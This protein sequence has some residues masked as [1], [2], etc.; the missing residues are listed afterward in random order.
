MNKPKGTRGKNSQKKP[1]PNTRSSGVA[2]ATHSTNPLEGKV[3]GGTLGI[4]D[5]GLKKVYIL[6]LVK[7]DIPTLEEVLTPIVEGQLDIEFQ[8]NLIQDPKIV[9][10]ASKESIPQQLPIILW[11]KMVY[12]EVTG[13]NHEE[14]VTFEF[15][16]RDPSG[17]TQMKN[18]PSSTLPRFHGLARKDPDAFL[19]EFDVLCRIYYYS[20]TTHKLKLFP[21]TLKGASLRW[22]MGLGGDNIQNL[23]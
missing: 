16:N 7:E 4:G 6:E 19:F 2:S 14:I 18:I 11:H 15:P 20:T 22:F 5:E 12:E 1:N 8:T 21:S 23:G 10:A 3:G 17:T 13:N 9:A